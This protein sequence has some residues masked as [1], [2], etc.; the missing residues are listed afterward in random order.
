M[1]PVR[2]LCTAAALAVAAALSAAPAVA[3]DASQLGLES[4][5]NQQVSSAS[6]FPQ[7]VADAPSAVTVITAEDIRRMGAADLPDVLRMVA[8][9]NLRMKNK[10]SYSVSLRNDYSLMPPKLLLLVDGRASSVELHDTPLWETLEVTLEQVERIEVIRGPGSAL[11]GANAYDGVISITTKR[12]TGGTQLD[13][14]V[15]VGEYGEQRATAVARQTA[16]AFRLDGFLQST[17]S[18][19]RN[20]WTIGG[21]AVREADDFLKGG[22]RLGWSNP[23]GVDV[24]LS[25]GAVSGDALRL[26]S[27]ARTTGPSR[28]SYL[29]LDLTHPNIVSDAT[30]SGRVYRT[31]RNVDAD[32]T[33]LDAEVMLD[34]PLG[35]RHRAILGAT[36]KRTDSDPVAG[37]IPGEHSL[38]A[39][40]AFLQDVWSLSPQ[41]QVTAG[42]R[43]DHHPLTGLNLSPRATLLFKPSPLHTL[44]ASAGRAFRNPTL[45]ESYLEFAQ[46]I[47]G[48]LSAVVNGN[49]ALAPE[50]ITSWELGYIGAPHPR[51]LVTANLFRNSQDDRIAAKPVQIVT[52]PNGAHVP[53]LSEYANLAPRTA[54]GA[55]LG[56]TLQPAEWV[57]FETNY[58]YTYLTEEGDAGTLA[59]RAAP[60]HKANVEIAV[61]PLR[62]VWLDLTQRYVSR[63]Q[64]SAT[65]ELPAE[66]IFDLNTRLDLGRG[67]GVSV[68]AQNLFDARYADVINGEMLGRRVVGKLSVAF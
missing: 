28:M 56:L 18:E 36:A 2:L 35:A 13:A 33:R 12:P 53:V 44:R 55:E 15:A 43:A 4:L 10:G 68:F 64:P 40:A 63:S 29:Q 67:L 30:L 20:P 25:A 21:V 27:S 51:V 26:W 57:Y 32:V 34:K 24:Q 62:Q 58:A 61:R 19:V 8:G 46:P 65:V 1:N 48:G 47:G 5:L 9:L 7:R 50:V 38:T 17:H 39:W 6:K 60:R 11:Y 54:T 3:Q 66:G 31:T 37:I 14:S 41:W 22:G 16:G 49:E 42:A 45:V 52:L 59:V 23:A